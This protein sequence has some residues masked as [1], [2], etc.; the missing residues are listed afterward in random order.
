MSLLQETQCMY[1][2]IDFIKENKET[3][4]EF[5]FELPLLAVEALN[6][7]RFAGHSQQNGMFV[8]HEIVTLKKNGKKRDYNFWEY[9]MS[10]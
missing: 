4:C 8:L 3:R 10:M 9:R 2:N 5:M 1:S 6:I 7:I